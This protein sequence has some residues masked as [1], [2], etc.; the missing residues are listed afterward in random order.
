VRSGS[1]TNEPAWRLGQC[2]QRPRTG[3]S[4]VPC[5]PPA[6]AGCRGRRRGVVGG[7]YVSRCRALGR[8]FA[9]RRR[10][11]RLRTRCSSRDRRS[12]GETPPWSCTRG[13]S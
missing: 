4:T 10:R 1:Q 2:R 8:R 5:I 11:G 9:V 6:P 12:Y 7:D 13:R 3:S